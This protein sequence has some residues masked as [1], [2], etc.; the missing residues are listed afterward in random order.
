[1]TPLGCWFRGRLIVT[2]SSSLALCFLPVGTV[3]CLSW[4]FSATEEIT[5]PRKKLGIE[6]LLQLGSNLI[7]ILDNPSLLYRLT[8]ITFLVASATKTKLPIEKGR[9][10]S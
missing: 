8:L 6:T 7:G 5:V 9:N 3:L 4:L 2:Q 10:H 1:M